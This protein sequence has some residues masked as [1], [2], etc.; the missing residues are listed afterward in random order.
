MPNA[1]VPGKSDAAGTKAGMPSPPKRGVPE[2]LAAT[3]RRV[4]E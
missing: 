2:I 1:S 4:S 3:G